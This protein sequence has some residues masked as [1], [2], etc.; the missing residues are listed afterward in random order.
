MKGLFLNTEFSTAAKSQVLQSS[1]TGTENVLGFGVAIL[2]FFNVSFSPSIVSWFLIS[3]YI[4]A[5]FPNLET[6]E[7]Y[8]ALS[9]VDLRVICIR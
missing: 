1:F 2:F 8:F 4:K 7:I 6:Q 5:A 3:Q 9:G